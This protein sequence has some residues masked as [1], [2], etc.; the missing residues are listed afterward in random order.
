MLYFSV[1]LPTI[2]DVLGTLKSFSS[3]LLGVMQEIADI[4]VELEY[5]DRVRVDN[6]EEVSSTS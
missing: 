5:S 6:I 3:D 2:K 4:N 1:P